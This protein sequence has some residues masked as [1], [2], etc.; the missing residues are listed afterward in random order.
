MEINEVLKERGSKYGPFS[1]HAMITQSL[2]DVFKG[3]GESV[4][5]ETNW[6]SLD[7]FQ[8][9]ALEMIAHKIGRIL[10]GDPDY[11]DSW[12]DIAGYAQLVVDILNGKDT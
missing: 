7:D 10:N 2:K 3:Q 1:G 5:F 11:D 9:E 8:K 6:Y 4:N 12:R